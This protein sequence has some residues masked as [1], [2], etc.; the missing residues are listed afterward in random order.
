MHSD[1]PRN[2]LLITQVLKIGLV[3]KDWA[4]R[5]A[6]VTASEVE[7]AVRTL[8]ASKEGDEMRK[9]ALKLR[10]AVLESMDE[11]G[12][13]RREMDSFIAHISR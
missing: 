2:M 5:D 1:Q 10:D 3:V 12:F 6:L 7:K 4:K 8:M 11:G 13:S 9:T